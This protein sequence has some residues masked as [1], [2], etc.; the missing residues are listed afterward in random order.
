MN[1]LTD[2]EK[3]FTN[4]IKQGDIYIGVAVKLPNLDEP[5]IIINPIENF[6]EKLKY[7]KNA[8]TDDL[9]L[10]TCKDIQIVGAYS[11]CFAD[12][13]VELLD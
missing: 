2:L 11:S 9:I 13:I 6:E 1:T 3:V 10:K 8:Y 12:D 7:Y 5:E 4:A